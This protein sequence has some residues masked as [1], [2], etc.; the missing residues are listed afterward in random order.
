VEGD[1]I[2]DLLSEVDPRGGGRAKLRQPAEDGL[3]RLLV[4]PE[5]RLLRLRLQALDLP[6]LAGDVKDAPGIGVFSALAR[7]AA[8]SGV[9]VLWP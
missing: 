6:L 9:Q 8:P 7:L 4:E 1:E 3:G 5:V 2:F